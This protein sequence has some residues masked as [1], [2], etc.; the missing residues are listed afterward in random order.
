MHINKNNTNFP[1]YMVSP[2]NM[3]CIKETLSNKENRLVEYNPVNPDNGVYYKL[4]NDK[5]EK[6][7]GVKH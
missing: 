5:I 7:F 4:T 2:V 1:D 6:H 3:E